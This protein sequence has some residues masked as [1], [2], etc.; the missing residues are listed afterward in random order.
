MPEPPAPVPAPDEPEL[1]ACT[2]DDLDEVQELVAAYHRHEGIAMAPGDRRRTIARLI[3]DPDLGGLWLVRQQGRTLGYVAVCLGY[4]IEFG[5]RDAFLDELYLVD[6]ARG[7]GIG[8]RVIDRVADL[9]AAQ[10]VRAVHLEVARDNAAALRL[11][12]RAAFTL[13]NTFHLMS[14]R[15]G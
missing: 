5:G 7:R 13:R 11:Y 3:A 8:R 15:L 14:R 12:G 2:P 9:L 6:S 1:V 4:S 10:N